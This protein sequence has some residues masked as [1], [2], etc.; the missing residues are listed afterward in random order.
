MTRQLS[1]FTISAAI[2]ILVGLTL[3]STAFSPRSLAQRS[4]KSLDI[5]RHADEPLEWLDITVGSQSLKQKVKVKS[6]V[7]HNAAEGLDTVDFDGEDD[8]LKKLKFKVR[9]ISNKT[10][11]GV[12]ASLYFNPGDA[13]RMFSA[14]LV[15]PSGPLEGAVLEPGAQIDVLVD[16]GS[17]NRTIMRLRAYGADPGEATVSLAID[18]V[19]FDDGIMWR[20]GRLIKKDPANPNRWIPAQSNSPPRFS[21]LNHGSRAPDI[22][23]YS[24]RRARGKNISSILTPR[25]PQLL[26]RCV[27][28]NDTGQF[29]QCVAAGC[30]T[31]FELG[32]GP[33]TS[34]IRQV[35]S[36]CKQLP[37]P[38]VHPWTCTGETTHELLEFDPTCDQPPPTPTPGCVGNGE[39]Y[40]P[41]GWPCCH[42]LVPNNGTCGT[43]EPTP[44]P[45]VTPPPCPGGIVV[46][47]PPPW[48]YQ[49]LPNPFAN[50]FASPS[51]SPSSTPQPNGWFCF[52][53]AHCESGYCRMPPADDPYK[54]ATP[55]DPTPTPTPECQFQTTEDPWLDGNDCGICIDGADNDCDFSTDWQETTCWARCW[56]PVVIDVSGNGFDLT[57]ASSGVAF[58]LNSNGVAERLSWTAAGSDDAWLAL[59]RNGNGFIDNGQELFGNYTPQPPSQRP[60]GFLALAE[61]DRPA[62]GGNGDGRINSQDGI[63]SSLRLWQDGNHNGIS[64]PSELHGLLSLGVAVVDLD[65]KES[66]RRD[67]YGNLFRY[68]AKVR[69][70][71][72]AQVGRWVW[73]VFL[74]TENSITSQARQAQGI[75]EGKK[76]LLQLVGIDVASGFMSLA[77]HN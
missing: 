23:D 16:E 18:M 32:G 2:L 64:E 40:L 20:K 29:A 11:L 60:N 44:S 26:P 4:K 61:F 22:D 48:F 3:Y 30:F 67:E 57:N 49:C 43:P 37:G 47:V 27:W 38:V 13:H 8:W 35:T 36:D 46:P 41:F 25:S 42:P 68:R 50:P 34:S 6:R 12:S 77:W 24:S 14:T 72:G 55:P 1:F 75:A 56:S 54:C 59:D 74:L 28:D 70:T 19:A 69:D 65:Y 10:I 5:R 52:A 9:N 31:V 45:S 63:F 21:R 76:D 62:T 15:G 7:P 66:K 39:L 51:P 53:D 73:D 17:L 71:R 33:G 58:D